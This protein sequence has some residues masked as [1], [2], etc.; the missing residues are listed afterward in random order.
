V[1]FLKDR[2]GGLAR[3]DPNAATYPNVAQ[4]GVKFFWSAAQPAKFADFQKNATNLAR[5]QFEDRRG[6]R[7]PDMR[8]IVLQ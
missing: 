8:L 6:C 7:K 4:G 5:L 1:L 3:S 2:A